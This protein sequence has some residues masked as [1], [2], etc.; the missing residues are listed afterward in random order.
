MRNKT[1]VITGGE[2]FIGSALAEHLSI[3][4]KIISLDNHLN[5]FQRQ[6]HEN[7]TYFDA[8]AETISTVL[9]GIKPDLVYH[10]GEYARV[11]KSFD[12]I[13]V[14]LRNNY[15]QFFEVCEYCSKTEAKL[16]YSGSSTIFS[17]PQKNYIPSPYQTFKK[18]NVD[19]LSDYAKYKKLNYAIVYFYN[20]YGPG[21]IAEGEFATVIAK[22]INNAKSGVPLNVSLPGT[23]R[24]NFTH[25]FDIVKGLEMVGMHGTGDEYGIGAR[26]SYSIL[27]VAKMVSR[28]VTF[29][30]AVEGNRN[31][32]ILKTEKIRA[33]GWCETKS[34]PDYLEEELQIA[35]SV[36]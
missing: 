31:D 27:E 4:N 16:I 29:T 11:E 32:A 20:V 14:I 28:N 18:H 17:K 19:F 21:E 22:F 7:V 23:Q 35:N 10:L 36:K 24:R 33:M 26:D 15:R 9:N 34:L 13:D 8:D 25:I 6:R 2:G 1:I 3:N 30:P 5:N 12:Q